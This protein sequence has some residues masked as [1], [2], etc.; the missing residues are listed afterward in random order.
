MRAGKS[1]AGDYLALGAQFKNT[2]GY[3]LL[4]NF[5]GHLQFI[6]ERPGER[7]RPTEIQAWL[8]QTVLA[9]AAATRLHREVRTSRRPSGRNAQS[10]STCLG[11]IGDDPQVIQQA[12]TMVQALHAAIRSRWTPR[13]PARCLAVA[14]RHGDAEL[15][16]QFKAQHESREVAGTVLSLF[17]RAWATSNQQK[18]IEQ[19]LASTLTPEVRSQDLYMLLER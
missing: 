19:T 18:L 10:C 16:D 1:Q 11:N 4:D 8:R 15:Y 5:A 3:V 14:A 13:W 12:R 6:N 17:P 9:D 2:P 7:C